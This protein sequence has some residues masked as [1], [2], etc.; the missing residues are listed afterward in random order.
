MKTVIYFLFILTLFVLMP[1][2]IVTALSWVPTVEL[3]GNSGRIL[4]FHVPLAFLSVLSFVT[5][6]YQSL[7]VLITS[8]KMK[9]REYKAYNAAL[10]GIF[11]TILTIITGSIWAKI[12]WGSFWN[13]DPRETSIVYLMLIYISYFCL[14]SVLKDNENRYRISSVY[15]II[16]M[17]VMPFF[18]FIIPRMY[19][20]LHPNTIINSEGKI[21]LEYTMRLTLFM[22]IAVFTLLY[23]YIYN[24]MNRISALEIKAEEKIYDI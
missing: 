1:A 22:S 16:A 12:S 10:A 5:A 11:F 9:E 6:G 24:I 7:M 19:N 20:S 17:I 14:Y 13:W 18:V 15:L 8:N 23:G 21:Q 4:Y 3:L 2:V